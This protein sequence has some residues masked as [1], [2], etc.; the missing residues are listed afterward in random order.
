MLMMMMCHNMT[1]LVQFQGR[2][3]LRCLTKYIHLFQVRG[4]D[5]SA[6][7]SI[8]AIPR[9]A[10]HPHKSHVII[11]G[12]GGFGLELAHWLVERGAKYLVLTS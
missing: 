7:L 9:T 8:S 10:S 2:K 1:E 4:D 6:S 12:L 5:E 11:G 3:Q